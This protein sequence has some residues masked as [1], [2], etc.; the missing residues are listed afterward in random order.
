MTF[1]FP[2]W[3]GAL[4]AATWILWPPL[5]TV[6]VFALA[7]FTSTSRKCSIEGCDLSAGW[8]ITDLIGTL[9]LPLVVTLLWVRWRRLRERG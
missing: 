7:F 2:Y 1:K 6:V 8:Q 5:W 3:R 9:V 4:V